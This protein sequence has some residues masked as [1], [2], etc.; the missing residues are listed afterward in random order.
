MRTSSRYLPAMDTAKALLLVVA[1]LLI[2][3][4]VLYALSIWL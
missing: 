1:P 2:I 4:A 3:V